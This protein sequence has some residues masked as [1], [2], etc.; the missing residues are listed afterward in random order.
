MSDSIHQ[1]PSY[2][3]YGVVSP[4]FVLLMKMFWAVATL[5]GYLVTANLFIVCFRRV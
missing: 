5:R 3:T 4:D 1:I 2:M